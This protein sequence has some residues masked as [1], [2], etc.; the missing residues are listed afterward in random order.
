MPLGELRA[1]PRRGD[2][3]GMRRWLADMAA[4]VVPHQID[5]NV[6][7]V[8]DVGARRQ[9]GGELFAGGGLHVVQKALLLGRAVPAVL[10]AD[11]MA[12]GEIE[13]GDV[14][15][16]AEGML[17]NMRVGIAVHAAA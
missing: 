12:V 8:I 5:V 6:I 14:E 13:F 4:V 7:V 15:R 16:V 1:R 10:H 11:L 3:A 17:G 9:H 2:F